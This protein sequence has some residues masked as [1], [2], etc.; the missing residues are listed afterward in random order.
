VHREARVAYQRVEEELEG[1]IASAATALAGTGAGAGAGAGAGSSVLNAGPHAR[2]EV[3]AIPRDAAD[4]AGAGQE[5]SDGR[6]ATWAAAPAVGIGAV[7]A[8]PPAGTPPVTVD[9][10]ALDNGLIRVVLDESGLIT[11]VYDHLSAR[12]TIAA[13]AAGNLLQVHP[14]HPASW[15][16]WNLDRQYR[17]RHTDLT[18]V[19]AIEIVDRGPLLGSIRVRRSFGSSSVAQTLV[20]RA[21]S[22]RL[23][24]ATEI[25][26]RES[27]K[28]LKAAFPFDI[29][30]DRESAEIQFGHVHRSI[31]TNTSWDAARFE[32]HAHRWVHLDEA[33]YGIALLTGSTYGH[34]VGRTGREGAATTTTVRLTLLRAPRNPDPQTDQGVHRFVYALVPG[35]TVA[36]CVAEGYALNLPLRLVEP[37]RDARPLVTVDNPAVVVEAVKLADDRS[38]DVIVRLYE[39]LGGRAQVSVRAGI[40]LGGVHLVDLLERTVAEVS[41]PDGAV[42]LAL[43]PFEI[44][45]LRLSRPR[46]L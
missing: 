42:R 6:T 9:A 26:W 25:D 14:D 45:T 10:R 7:T 40:P 34:D 33:G 23:D 29:H 3:I 39:S 1:I 17:H 15:D 18:D 11:S 38:G 4:G 43:A 13:G 19:D 27:E 36:D 21:G 24:I 44:C 31:S 5:L 28:V 30:A 37:V 8:G 16:A 22:R 12:E 32:L 2:A 20:L 35:A 41:A 46:S